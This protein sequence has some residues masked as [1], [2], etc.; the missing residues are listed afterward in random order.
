MKNFNFLSTLFGNKD[1][2]SQE[3]PIPILYGYKNSLHNRK[4]D[5]RI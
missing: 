3:S 1:F 5:F 4:L 2:M